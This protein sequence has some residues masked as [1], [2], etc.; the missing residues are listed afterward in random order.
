MTPM[1]F[2]TEKFTD[3]FHRNDNSP[4]KLPLG[5]LYIA[6]VLGEKRKLWKGTKGLI[7]LHQFNKVELYWFC[8]PSKS[9]AIKRSLD[10][11]YLKSLTTLQISD[12][13]T[14]DLGFSSSRTFDLEVWLPSSKCYRDFKLQQLF[15]LSSSQ[16]IN[17]SKN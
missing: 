11:K 14:G 12:I 7:R 3:C 9:E 5:M 15:R 4:K 2:S 17:K 8:D 6:H 16:I 10:A 1:A 13:C